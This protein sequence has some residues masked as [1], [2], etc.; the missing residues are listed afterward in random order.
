MIDKLDFF[1]EA[2]YRIS[3][4]VDNVKAMGDLFHYL[5]GVMPLHALSWHFYDRTN[6]SL[7]MEGVITPKGI[8]GLDNQI[9][10]LSRHACKSADLV[11]TKHFVHFEHTAGD[12]L[13]K[14]IVQTMTR[15]IGPEDKSLLL[16]YLEWKHTPM[17]HL[18]VFR[19]EP[20][21]WSAEHLELYTMLQPPFSFAI[22]HMRH[23]MELTMLKNRVTEEKEFLAQELRRI[24]DH[25]IIGVD[26]GLR[27]IKASIEQLAH[28][29][30]PVLIMGETGVGKELV[31]NALQQASPRRDGPYVK[32]NCGA[33]PE[34]LIDSELFGHEKGAFT[35]AVNLRKGKFELA[36]KGTIFLDEIGELPA[37]VQVRLLRV[38]Q[39]H[40]VERVGGS[41]PI[42]VDVRFIV[43][44]HRNL[45]DMVRKRQ[46]REDLFFR[47]NVFPVTV[48][49]LRHRMQD[50][51]ALVEYLLKK[52]AQDMKLHKVPKLG[53][54]AIKSLLNH[55]WPGNVRELEN[56]VERAL[57]LRP[58]GPVDFKELLHTM[59]SMRENGLEN[60]DKSFLPLDDVN[61]RHIKCA[62]TVARGKING[63]GGAA[64]ILKIHPHTLRRRMDKL[65]INYGR[66]HIQAF[67]NNLSSDK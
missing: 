62:L 20:G 57:I 64:E 15:F 23:L 59:P 21:S 30:T 36:N 52:K 61:R 43:A 66:K 6:L 7:R 54:N 35:G 49:P 34:T 29:D 2:T 24:T 46:F 65:G 27:E 13:A 38:L 4:I 42:K 32:I 55:S 41:K 16:I 14:I 33:I 10:P 9:V 19:N 48:P 17:G 18:C 60:K 67:T 26:S 22:Y 45:L 28:V 50:I 56:L 53:P 58:K 39:N 40:E 8:F 12:P 47:I 63:P 44:T 25:E 37:Q 1:Q 3:L 5:S 31:A 51:P 11:N